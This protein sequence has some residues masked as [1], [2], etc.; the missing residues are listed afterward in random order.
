MGNTCHTKTHGYF[1][2][3][4]ED[5]YKK[6]LTLE[7]RR[8]SL[9][10]KRKQPECLESS[11]ILGKG[12]SVVTQGYDV[13]N[14]QVVAVKMIKVSMM[15]PD[16]LADIEREAHILAELNHKNIVSFFGTKFENGFLKIYM[17]YVDGGS[18]FSLIKSTGPLPE[19]VASNFTRQV[20][21]GLEYLHIHKIIHRDIKCANV[22][23]DRHG[24]VKLTDFGCAKEVLSVLQSYYGT[25]GWVAPEVG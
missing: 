4:E 1:S 8:S 25:S 13:N 21:E 23:V 15:A 11:A 5:H 7:M 18:L 22:L 17:E 6:K 10:P 14:K 16:A 9:R 2:K 19:E 3:E 12:N 20:L 24:K